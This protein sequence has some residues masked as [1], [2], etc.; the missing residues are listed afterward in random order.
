MLNGDSPAG[1]LMLT[2]L[3]DV[4][5]F[6]VSQLLSRSRVMKRS[7]KAGLGKGDLGDGW[8]IGGLE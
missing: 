8:S 7:H 2:R 6:V 1:V 3:Q 5:H 4:N